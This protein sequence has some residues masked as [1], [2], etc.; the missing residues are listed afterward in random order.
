MKSLVKYAL[1]RNVA[2]TKIEQHWRMM[3]DAQGNAVPVGLPTKGPS[4]NPPTDISEWPKDVS[5]TIAHDSTVHCLTLNRN[6]SVMSER[7]GT[8][9][10]IKHSTSST[11]ILFTKSHLMSILAERKSRKSMTQILPYEI[12]SNDFSGMS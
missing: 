2:D 5:T 7:L 1:E 9:S 8:E 6:K 11:S 12:P 4:I 3:R 10:E